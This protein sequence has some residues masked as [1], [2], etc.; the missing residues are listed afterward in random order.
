M[1]AGEQAYTVFKDTRELAAQ[2]AKMVDQALKGETV[3]VNDTKTYDNGVK[4]V[5]SYLFTPHSVDI[6][7]YVPVLG[8]DGAERPLRP[9]V[10]AVVACR[11]EQHA[12]VEHLVT[13]DF[14]ATAYRACASQVSLHDPSSHAFPLSRCPF[15][16]CP[17]EGGGTLA[18]VAAR[19]AAATAESSQG[20]VTGPVTP[21]FAI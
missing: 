5:S 21:L 7:N 9:A 11:E 3:D 12:G 16:G 6:S 13:R 20:A 15:P 14:A 17:G 8:G 18:E 4:I 10:V 2:T 1:I 19:G